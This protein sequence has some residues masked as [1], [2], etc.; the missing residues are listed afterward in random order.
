MCIRDSTT[1]DEEIHYFI[2]SLEAVLAN[3]SEWKQDYVY[4]KHINEFIHKDQQDNPSES[5]KEWFA[6]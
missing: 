2:S 4:L 6:L 3:I 1:T 5:F